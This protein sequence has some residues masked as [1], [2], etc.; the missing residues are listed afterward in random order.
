[1]L[2]VAVGVFGHLGM[3]VAERLREQ[4]HGV[5]VVDPR[6]VKPVD[7]ALVDLAGAHSLVV[8]LEDNGRHGGVGASFTQ[9]ARDAGVETPIRV[10][11]VEQEFLDHAK[12]DVILGRL[13]LTVEAVVEDTVLALARNSANG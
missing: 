10:H 5:T 8:T 4:G 1:V 12:R 2:V 3:T 13:G 11:G 9:A 7:P 6:W